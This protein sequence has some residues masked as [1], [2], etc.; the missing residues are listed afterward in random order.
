[1]DENVF[2]LCIKQFNYQEEKSCVQKLLWLAMCAS[3]AI[4]TLLKKR[5]IIRIVWKSKSFAVSATS[6]QIIEKQDKGD[7][8]G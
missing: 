5:K 7:C 4:T 8:N 3:N 2:F 6:T 1:V